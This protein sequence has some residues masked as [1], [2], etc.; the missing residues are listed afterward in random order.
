M[1]LKVYHYSVVFY[2]SDAIWNIKENW[3]NGLY[4]SLEDYI[5]K[6]SIL[7]IPSSLK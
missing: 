7:Q 3:V 1:I 6:L 5:L 4:W 2:N